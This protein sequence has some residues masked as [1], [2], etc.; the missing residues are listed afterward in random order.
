M[1]RWFRSL[2]DRVRLPSEV[3]GLMVAA[4][5]DAKRMVGLGEALAQQYGSFMADPLRRVIETIHRHPRMDVVVAASQWLLPPRYGILLRS[6]LASNR[7]TDAA[8]L[9]RDDFRAGALMDA[10]HRPVAKHGGSGGWLAIVF[11]LAFISQWIIPTFR[12]LFE[13]FGLDL[14]RLTQ[15]IINSGETISLL[16]WM[17]FVVLTASRIIVWVM[18]FTVADPHW[19][20]HGLQSFQPGSHRSNAMWAVCGLV[21]LGHPLSA[22]VEDVAQSCATRNPKL[23]SWLRRRLHRVD[24]AASA[25]SAAENSFD[26]FGSGEVERLVTFIDRRR[27]G[28]SIE[29]IRRCLGR[30]VRGDLK[31][32]TDNDVPL[33]A[34][35][36]ASLCDNRPLGSGVVWTAVRVIRTAG[37]IGLAIAIGGI[38]IGLFMPLVALVR[39]LTG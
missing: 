9:C 19:I 12:N 22:A 16:A 23:A 24:A 5:G 21:R 35:Y 4:N 6:A 28:G 32:L 26:R 15:T 37:I 7:T 20:T 30:S 39:G 8:E 34:R 14:P 33:A 3:L 10:L 36:C 18:R 1:I 2:Q 11:V 29:W 38:V 13:E 25:P 31:Q 27:W 17:L